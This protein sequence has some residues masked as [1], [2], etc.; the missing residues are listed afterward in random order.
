MFLFLFL[1]S[2]FDRGVVTFRIFI[3]I[4]EFR[5]FLHFASALLRYVLRFVKELFL[6]FFSFSLFVFGSVWL[7]RKQMKMREKKWNL[8][9]LKRPNLFSGLWVC[10]SFS[11]RFG[12]LLEVYFFGFFKRLRNVGLCCF[13]FCCFYLFSFIFLSFLSYQTE[14]EFVY[15]FIL[16]VLK[17]IFIWY[18]D[19]MLCLD[20][21]LSFFDLREKAKHMP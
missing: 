6:F 17:L 13:C 1:F 3:G 2:F 19:V 12:V 8:G 21:F 9:F 7:L 11:L 20:L 4:D 16:L 5:C 18:F 14:L 15:L 10:F